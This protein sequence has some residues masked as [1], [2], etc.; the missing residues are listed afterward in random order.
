MSTHNI[1][2]LWRNKKNYPRIITENSLTTHLDTIF[3]SVLSSATL[4]VQIGLFEYLPGV[5]T[6]YLFF[7]FNGYSGCPIKVWLCFQCDCQVEDKSEIKE[8]GI[9]LVEENIY[10]YR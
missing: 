7:F 3:C 5:C 9:E 8:C 2:F 6:I 1:C 4:F 10:T